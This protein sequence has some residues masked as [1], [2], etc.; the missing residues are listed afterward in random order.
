M[1]QIKQEVLTMKIKRKIYGILSA[2]ILF[3]LFG[4]IGSVECFV[5]ELK[6]GIILTII[7][8]P[9]FWLFFTLSQR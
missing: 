2:V 4:I 5:I 1:Y 8:L 6:L 7:L 9:S 3:F